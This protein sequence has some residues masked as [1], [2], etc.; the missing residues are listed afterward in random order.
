MRVFIN[1]CFIL[2]FK[3]ENV[4]FKQLNSLHSITRYRVIKQ[5]LRREIDNDTSLE[6][7]LFIEQVIKIYE[8]IYNSE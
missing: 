3:I 7:Q 1:A 4:V 8:K 6:N 5:S 2:M